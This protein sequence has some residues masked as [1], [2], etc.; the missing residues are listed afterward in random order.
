ME[1]REYLTETGKNPFR[2]WFVS[3]DTN[4]AVRVTARLRRLEQNNF[5]NVNSVG[6]GVA[7]LRLHFGP[8]YRI[9]FGRAH[10]ELV[11]LLA[12]GTKHRQQRDIKTAQL[13]WNNYRLR[14][15]AI[16]RGAH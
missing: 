12:G 14:K 13:R 5:A 2:D 10:Q 7:E 9:Y 6:Q 1:V 16:Q 11:I 15:Q 3:L 4:T 8:G